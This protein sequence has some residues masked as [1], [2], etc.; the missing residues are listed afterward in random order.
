VLHIRAWGL[1]RR[2]GG[3][4]EGSLACP[5]VT[6]KAPRG[7]VMTARN[8]RAVRLTGR[9]AVYVS[10]VSDPHHEH[11]QY[12]IANGIHHAVIADSDTVQV[13]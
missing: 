6:V 13:I 3:E 2:A 8:G 9:P 12:I 7:L 1:R 10:A 11:E 5:R 4:T